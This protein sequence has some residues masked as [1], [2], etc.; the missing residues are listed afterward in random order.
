MARFEITV[1]IARPVEEVFATLADPARLPEWQSSAVEVHAHGPI[2]PGA[3][4]HEVRSVMG[5]RLEGTTEVTEYEPPRLFSVRSA[6]GPV[7]FDVRHTLE[8]SEGGTRVDVVAEG[9]ATGALR[10][11]GPM[12]LRT[13]EREFR[14]DFERLKELLEAE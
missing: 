11:A 6:T 10:L 14:R 1:E 13:A 5:R 8:P 3:H 9:E 7:R 4:F 12:V 2:E